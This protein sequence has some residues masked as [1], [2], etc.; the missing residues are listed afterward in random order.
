[1]RITARQLRQIIK[2]EVENMMYEEPLPSS[3]VISPVTQQNYVEAFSAIESALNDSLDLSMGATVSRITDAF[4]GK[5]QAAVDILR[6]EFSPNGPN[7]VAITEGRS[8]ATACVRSI[9][10][11]HNVA[12]QV[13]S[14]LNSVTVR[15]PNKYSTAVRFDVDK[16]VVSA[17][18][19]KA[20]VEQFANAAEA[21]GAFLI[22]KFGA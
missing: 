5:D 19:G 18:T 9:L 13:T 22:K 14:T 10:A 1:M 3:G 17:V 12:S 2:E 7:K 4:R 20:G 8:Y 11:M 21:A 6:K 15:T 16:D